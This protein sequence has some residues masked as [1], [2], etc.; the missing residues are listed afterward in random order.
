MAA[1]DYYG[2]PDY[3]QIVSPGAAFSHGF[4]HVLTQQAAL[5][6]QAILDQI[7]QQRE[8]RLAEAEAL[9]NE[10]RHAQLKEKM[11]EA[12]DREGSRWIDHYTKT[13]T[14]GDIPSADQLRRATELGVA[15][16]FEEDPSKA[17]APPPSQTMPLPGAVTPGGPPPPG[18]EGPPPAAIRFAP[19]P[20]DTI[21]PPPGVG[22]PPTPGDLRTPPPGM[23]R[24]P[25]PGDI[26]T[27]PGLTPPPPPPSATIGPSPSERG[28]KGPL[29]YPG[30]A[31]EQEQADIQQRAQALLKTMPEGQEKEALKFWLATDK[32]APAAYFGTKQKQPELGTFGDY[33]WS[34]SDGHPETLTVAQKEAARKRWGEEGRSPATSINLYAIGDDGKPVLAGTIPHGSRV[35]PQRRITAADLNKLDPAQL[36]AF[37]DIVKKKTAE[38]SGI[39]PTWLGGGIDDETQQR[40]FEEAYIEAQGIKPQRKPGAA[41]A[42]GA[43]APPAAPET[44]PNPLQAILDKLNK[45]Q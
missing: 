31:K 23:M 2:N 12:H 35:L 17:V 45:R 43:G 5:R 13:H 42:P 19:N 3:R 20:G 29:A 14:R 9:D 36:V 26:V 38:L 7:A 24:P 8:A 30:S 27:P 28:L 16:I 18:M 34:I 32:I 1:D 40:I 37:K 25:T 21:S 33:L 41:A 6:R 44:P 11:D 15:D 22:R 4:E 39:L 10:I